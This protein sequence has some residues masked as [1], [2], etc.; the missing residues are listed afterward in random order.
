MKEDKFESYNK[1]PYEGNGWSKYQLMVLQQLDDHNKVL[2]NLNKELADFRQLFAVSEAEYK[3][4]RAQ[5]MVTVDELSKKVTHILYDEKGIGTRTSILE[6]DAV[7]DEKVKL[8]MKTFWALVGAIL[9]FV[10]N[11]LVKFLDILWK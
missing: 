11:S 2:Q 3:L 4:W 8:K 6:R 1:N 7:T 5:T 9:A 10:G